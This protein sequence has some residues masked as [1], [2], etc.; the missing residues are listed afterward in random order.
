MTGLLPRI[1][2]RC[3]LLE[4]FAVDDPARFHAQ[5]G[6][7]ERGRLSGLKWQ[8]H[9]RSIEEKVLPKGPAET[10]VYGLGNHLFGRHA[11]RQAF[12]PHLDRCV[13]ASQP[14]HTHRELSKLPRQHGHLVRQNGNFKRRA[15]AT[16]G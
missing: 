11:V 1:K 9:I 5:F 12:Y 4:T 15:G 10:G 14:A 13:P 6:Y 7:S 8:V 3:G 16:D 2:D